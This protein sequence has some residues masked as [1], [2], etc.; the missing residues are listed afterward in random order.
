MSIANQSEPM[1]FVDRYKKET[2]WHGKVIV[3][4]I[5]HLIMTH[6]MPDWTI[7]R[8]AS[9]FGVSIGLVSENL[10]LAK[11][12]H[13]DNNI[14]SCDSRQKALKKLNGREVN[15]ENLEA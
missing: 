2:T 14:F 7:T 10:K 9:H 11:A 8:T 15:V 1:T 4:E 6:R 12:L 5:Y 3:M 13:N